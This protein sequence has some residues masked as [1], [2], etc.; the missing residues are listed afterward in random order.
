MTLPN[1][2]HQN[3]LRQEDGRRS[4]A[5]RAWVRGHAC[6]VPGCEDRPIECVHVRTGTDGGLGVKPSDIWTVSLCR[7]H[8]SE[9]HR[10]GEA[11]FERAHGIDLKRLA[12][13]F[14]ARSPHRSKMEARNA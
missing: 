4:P 6:C 9:Q 1:R 7:D 14:T 10:I 8:H 13:E 11:S 5:H 3:S 12:S 2:L